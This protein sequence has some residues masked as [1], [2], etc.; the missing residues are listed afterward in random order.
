MYVK[1]D[2]DRDSPPCPLT[3]EDRFPISGYGLVTRCLLI[4]NRVRCP[5]LWSIRGKS[6]SE[7]R[8]VGGWVLVNLWHSE[9]SESK[10]YPFI[11]TT[12]ITTL[13]TVS[14]ETNYLGLKRLPGK[15][16][17]KSKHCRK[18]NSANRIIKSPN[19]HWWTKRSWI[20]ALFIL[21]GMCW[22]TFIRWA[23]N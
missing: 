13:L 7:A 14:P 18:F 15:D 20:N 5:S 3:M 11:S 16:R 17:K 12:Q 9:N 2:S 1:C 4:S 19:A 22:F 23:T 21:T 10:R 8:R 6:E